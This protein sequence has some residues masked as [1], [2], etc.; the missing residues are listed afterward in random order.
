M[1]KDENNKDKANKTISFEIKKRENSK[2][3]SV[4]ENSIQQNTTTHKIEVD[5]VN[6]L[7][8]NLDFND[9]KNLKSEIKTKLNGYKSQDLKK[10][11]YDEKEFISFDDTVEKL[12][13]SKLKCYYCN[14]GLTIFYNDARQKNQWTLERIDNSICH[15]KNN[16]VVSCLE[17]NLKRRCI[18]SNRFKYS[19]QF[20]NI[21]KSQF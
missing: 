17:C 10:K 14:C 1:N 2:K 13:I 16:V 3:T 6:K 20:S 18:D 7:Y 9:N 11:R 8:F 21:K 19:K 4:L 12:V 15:S 5:Y